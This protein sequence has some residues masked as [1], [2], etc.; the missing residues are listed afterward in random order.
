MIFLLTMLLLGEPNLQKPSFENIV[1]ALPEHTEQAWGSYLIAVGKTLLN[2]PYKEKLLE[3]EGDERLVVRLDGYDCVTF[4]ET[5]MA[6]AYMRVEGEQSRVAFDRVLRDLRYRKGSI[7][8]YGSRLHYTCDWG[9]DNGTLGYVKDVT[10]AIGGLPYKK[11]VSFM[12][13]NPQYYAALSDENNLNAVKAAEKAINQRQYFYIP[14]DKLEGLENKIQD[15]DILALT[16]KVKNLDIAH[17]GFA[18]HKDGRL[19]LLHA[20]SKYNRVIV[21]FNPLVDDLKESPSRHGVMV[22]RPQ[23]KNSNG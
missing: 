4:V 17:L 13:R 7:D 23:P 15:G 16:T 1:Q 9:F 18:I 22:F 21:S 19:H 3:V 2:Q 10:K 8:G 11:D 14:E 12:S 5:V 20:S 6:L